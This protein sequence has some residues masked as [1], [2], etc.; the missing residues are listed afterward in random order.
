MLIYDNIYFVKFYFVELRDLVCP[1]FL[2]H[3][4]CRDLDV[5]HI[6]MTTDIKSMEYRTNWFW[7]G[8]VEKGSDI[9]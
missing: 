1:C 6:T 7:I 4:P 3:R 2:K 5:I 8:D 9:T